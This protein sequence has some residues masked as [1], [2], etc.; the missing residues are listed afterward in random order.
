MKTE[1]CVGALFEH[2]TEHKSVPNHAVVNNTL[3]VLCHYY[4]AIRDRALNVSGT[5]EI[6]RVCCN[7]SSAESYSVI[8][9]NDFFSPA[10]LGFDQICPTHSLVEAVTSYQSPL[11]QYDALTYIL[12]TLL[13]PLGL[14]GNFLIL[15]AIL[16]LKCLPRQTGNFLTSLALADIG[17]MFQYCF[18]FIC[19]KAR[20]ALPGKLNFFFHPSIDIFFSALVLL[21]ITAI[22]IERAVAVTRPLKY[23]SLISVQRSKRI[24]YAIW[25][26][27]LFFFF[28]SM[29]RILVESETYQNFV[30]LTA[31]SILLLLPIVII[32]VCY[33]M[34]LVCAYKNLS[35]DRKRLQMLAAFI[36]RTHFKDNTPLTTA[37]GGESEA[38]VTTS[39]SNTSSSRNST[40]NQH[41]ENLK[42]RRNSIRCREF[43]LA[44]NV[45][46]IVLPFLGFWGTF[47]FVQ[48]YEVIQDVIFLGVINWLIPVLP[49]MAS[50]LN[51]ILYL[52]FTRSLRKAVKSLIQRKVK[53]RLSRTEV[54]MMAAT[55]SNTISFGN[56]NS[57]NN[58][59]KLP[60]PVIPLRAMTCRQ[61]V[62]ASQ[63]ALL[64]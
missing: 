45:A 26:I 29:S 44:I 52:T 31:A 37:A 19:V 36:R 46:M 25:L 35:Q 43:R 28:L 41:D 10:F 56:G 50:C 58:N 30:F 22:S 27:G 34:V 59:R 6:Q 11:K 47:L 42:Y 8:V 61:S 13:M 23:P 12:L 48:L 24:V 64:K 32:V 2:F 57:N 17:V 5:I 51:P 15:Y 9:C 1:E 63:E 60:I 39:S 3:S 16:K 20:L 21:Q 62:D 7:T 18:W 53:S 55:G 49:F 14:V 40:T 38:T 33:T 54:S 4:E